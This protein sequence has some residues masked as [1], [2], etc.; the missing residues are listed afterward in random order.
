MTEERREYTR[1][2]KRA[3][4]GPNFADDPAVRDMLLRLDQ[5]ERH[6]DPHQADSEHD[7]DNSANKAL[8]IVF[9]LIAYVAGWAMDHK[10]GLAI[11]GIG[12]IPDLAPQN[13]T[14]NYDELRKSV[15][16]HRHE[17]AGQSRDLEGGVQRKALCNIFNAMAASPRER[18][19][20]PL[21]EAL[22][23]L[24]YGETRP[25]L[26]PVKSGLKKG[27]RELT[28]QLFA[29]CFIE[30]QRGLGGRKYELESEVEKAF[31]VSRS[32]VRGWGHWLPKQLDPF[33]V[34]RALSRA[35]RLGKA[36][37]DKSLD[38]AFGKAALSKWGAEYKDVQ[39]F[40][41]PKSD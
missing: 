33:Y 11:E 31:G 26:E 8:R 28:L 1:R 21:A 32:T 40:T 14:P 36:D 35:R 19:L 23:G 6:T 10:T 24:E 4:D 3:E 41:K 39:G 13:R 15:N 29:L 12:N 34:A 27:F 25:I 9:D 7:K 2:L 38:Q 17:A 20:D 5:F 18:L 37:C 16:S 30:Y 22:L